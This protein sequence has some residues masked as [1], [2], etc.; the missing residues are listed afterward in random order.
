VITILHGGVAADFH[1]IKGCTCDN[2]KIEIEG[3]HYWYSP[4]EAKEE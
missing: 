4:Q 2:L 1:I 3:A